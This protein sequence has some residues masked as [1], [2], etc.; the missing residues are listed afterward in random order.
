MSGEEQEMR[1]DCPINSGGNGCG[2]R[3]A[4]PLAPL[5]MIVN[6]RYS[7]E[8]HLGYSVDGSKDAGLFLFSVSDFKARCGPPV[9][10]RRSDSSCARHGRLSQ[11]KANHGRECVLTLNGVRNVL[12][13]LQYFACDM[14]SF[15]VD[16]YRTARQTPVCAVSIAYCISIL[17]VLCFGVVFS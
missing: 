13:L 5:M 1:T 4:I 2:I 17:L 9:L 11:L 16:S 14:C 3:V 12:C 15:V 10:H 8:V 7:V 6:Q